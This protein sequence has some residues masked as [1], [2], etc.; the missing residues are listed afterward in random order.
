M[1]T[2]N[3]TYEQKGN[4]FVKGIHVEASSFGEMEEKFNKL[5]LGTLIGCVVVNQKIMKNDFAIKFNSLEEYREIEKFLEKEGYTN[6]KEW[7]EKELLEY[8]K[9][10]VC[11][12][13]A[14]INN[15][16][17]ELFGIFE[18]NILYIHETYSSLEEY[19]DKRNS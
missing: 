6:D 12:D 7:N 13:D 5:N 19:Y 18:D 10:F 14:I 3:I 8:Q 11:I 2:F 15:N 16:K 1:K 17:T 9:G 4:S